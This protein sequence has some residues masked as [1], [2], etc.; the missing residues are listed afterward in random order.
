MSFQIRTQTIIIADAVQ[1]T[2][3]LVSEVLRSVG[4]ES[5]VHARDGDE[6]LARTVEHEP[7]IVIT[8][9]RLPGMSGLEFTR[10]IRAGYQDVPRELSII[11]MT[12][13]PTKA[14]LDAAQNSGV[15]EM[16]V[17]PFTAQHLLIR[18]RAVLDH[19]R[20][21]VDSAKYIGPCRRRRM[22]DDYIGPMRRFVD[23]TDDMP[24]ALPWEQETNRAAVRTCVKKI[25]E[26]ATGLQPGDR[27]KLRE[28]FTAAKETESVADETKDAMLGAA[29]RSLG[30]YIMAIGANGHPDE[31]VMT[32]HIDAMHTLGMLTSAQHAERQNLVDGLVR[33]VDKRLGRTKAA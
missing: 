17:R 12:N 30:R 5:I 4:Y 20:E 2:R 24:G 28:I 29:A 21:F 7:T 3:N 33:I 11:V 26:M 9:S 22:V 25:S 6:L 27:R 32:T 13:T 14:F 8:T 1:Q 15:D 10:L 16:L 23:P 19:P 18:I 31:E